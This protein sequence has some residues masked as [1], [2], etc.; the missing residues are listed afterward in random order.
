MKQI[1]IKGLK[2]GEINIVHNIKTK[3]HKL[4]TKETLTH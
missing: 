2:F 3:V 1:K 4:K